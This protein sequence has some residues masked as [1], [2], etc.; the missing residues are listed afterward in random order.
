MLVMFTSRKIERDE[1]IRAFSGLV[2]KIPKASR[3]K[4]LALMGPRAFA[5]MMAGFYG[6]TVE[7]S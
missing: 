1:S 5:E 4:I 3:A 2:R 7:R 6:A